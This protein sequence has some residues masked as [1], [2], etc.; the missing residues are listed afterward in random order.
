MSDSRRRLGQ[1]GESVAE[2][3]LKDKGLQ[4]LERNWRCQLGEIDI[5]ALDDNEYVF[6]EVKTRKG[7][8]MGL[9][10]EGLTEKKARKL[11]DL[12]KRY[13]ADHDLDPDWRVDL[14]AIELDN[15]GKLLR[16]EHIAN[17]ILGW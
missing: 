1:W 16:C 2:L 8:Q 17:A 13:L 7:R 11:I 12:A 9:P 5:I 10:E 15:D 4:V 14:V 6:V 3:H